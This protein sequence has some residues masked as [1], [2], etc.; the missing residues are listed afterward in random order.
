MV[1]LEFGCWCLCG[2]PLEGAAARC[3]RQ[4]AVVLFVLWSLVAACRCRVPLQDVASW[5]C[6]QQFFLVASWVSAGVINI[7]KERERDTSCMPSPDGTVSALPSQ[8]WCKE[9]G[10]GV[11]SMPQ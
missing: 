6:C 4:S 3:C 7:L 5:E 2:V 11:V 10:S 1:L 8:A 9:I